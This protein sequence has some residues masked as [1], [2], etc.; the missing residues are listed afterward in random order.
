LSGYEGSLRYKLAVLIVERGWCVVHFHEVP[1][2]AIEADHR[3]DNALASTLAGGLVAAASERDADGA[4]LQRLQQVARDESLT[5]L[6]IALTNEFS[7]RARR[8]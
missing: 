3:D 8:R 7:A 5:I 2:A 4:L 1:V 6:P